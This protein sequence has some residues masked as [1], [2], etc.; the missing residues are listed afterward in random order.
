MRLVVYPEIDL[1]NLVANGKTKEEQLDKRH[2]EKN[3][4]C[5]PVTENVIKLLE[6]EASETV[7][8]VYW[9]HFDDPTNIF[10]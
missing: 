6:Q 1:L 2:T 7:H 9:L 8:S 4:R 5:S 3:G 10:Q